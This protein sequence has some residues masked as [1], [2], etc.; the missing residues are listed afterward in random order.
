[1]SGGARRDRTADLLRATE[2][3]ITHSSDLKP[4]PLMHKDTSSFSKL[5]CVSHT[6]PKVALFSLRSAKLT[7]RNKSK[8][9]AF[10]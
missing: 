6:C 3:P 8:L 4:H 1:M 5:Y 9:L 10:L 7:N 2:A